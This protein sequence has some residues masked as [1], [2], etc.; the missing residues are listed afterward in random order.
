MQTIFLKPECW[1]EGQWTC[2]FTTSSSNRVSLRL[3]SD[4][5]S[6]IAPAREAAQRKQRQIGRNEAV[7]ILW[8]IKQ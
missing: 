4:P 6:T 8:I 1:R 2:R 5:A 3:F 7:R